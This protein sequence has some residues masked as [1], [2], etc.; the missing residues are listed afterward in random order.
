MWEMRRVRLVT[1]KSIVT[2][3][4]GEFA[5]WINRED[6]QIL[7]SFSTLAMWATE[8]V[9]FLQLITQRWCES[10]VSVSTSIL[11][12]PKTACE[13]LLNPSAFLTKPSHSPA[14]CVLDGL[15]VSI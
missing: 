4:V 8:K 6:Y 7:L 3:V 10:R 11:P 12:R 5:A 13:V 2:R 1:S 14:R 15:I 9:M